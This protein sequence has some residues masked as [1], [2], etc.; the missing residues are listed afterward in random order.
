MQNRETSE[1]TEEFYMTIS[2]I[3]NFTFWEV[4]VPKL[5]FGIMHFEILI[6]RTTKVHEINIYFT[7]L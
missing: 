2:Y 5:R 6:I 1:K 4:S 7:V 3:F